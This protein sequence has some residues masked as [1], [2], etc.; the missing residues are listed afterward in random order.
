MK[1]LKF[2]SSAGQNQ[3]GGW[4]KVVLV[5]VEVLPAGS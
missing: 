4:S 5:A 1:V 3:R 2:V